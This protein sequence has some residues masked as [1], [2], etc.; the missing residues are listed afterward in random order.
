M[1]NELRAYISREGAI[2]IEDEVVCDAYEGVGRYMIV[3]HAHYDHVRGIHRA[4]RR[5]VRLI[6]TNAT[7]DILVALGKVRGYEVMGIEYDKDYD[8]GKGHVRLIRA[9]HILGSAQVVYEDQEGFRIAYTGDFRQPGTPIVDEPDVL[10][11]EATYG[12]RDM[13]RPPLEK[14]YEAFIDLVRRTFDR[15]PIS[16]FAY[17]GKIQEAMEVLRSAF[18][19]VPFL[20]PMR[21]LWLCEIARRHGM[22]IG[23]V[24]PLESEEGYEVRR[25][26]RYI[27]FYHSTYLGRINR[28][29]SISLSGWN[30]GKV[31]RK[32][33][34]RRYIVSISGHADFRQLMEYAEA[35]RPRL[36][37]VDGSRSTYAEAF[38]K[39]VK[40][41]LGLRAIVMP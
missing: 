17:H 6:S 33:G 1:L 16:I 10:I 20:A 27:A 19:D 13:I 28:G 3:T 2:V 30:I 12:R 18:P 39:E 34:A 24:I 21:I 22:K 14:V 32:I 15:E 9:N 4:R 36:L 41:R 37:L 35:A 8:V 40:R 25:G 7:K 26:G 23:K 29:I 31:V 11:M 38:A 5:G